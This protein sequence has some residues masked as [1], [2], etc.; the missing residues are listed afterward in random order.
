MILLTKI[1]HNSR[2]NVFLNNGNKLY[3]FINKQTKLELLFPNFKESNSYFLFLYK[4]I[5]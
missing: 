1:K 2:K 5:K 3:M 4:K